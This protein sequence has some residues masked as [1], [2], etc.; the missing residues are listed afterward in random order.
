MDWVDRTIYVKGRGTGDKFWTLLFVIFM[1]A[2]NDSVLLSLHRF[3][4]ELH[5]FSICLE[6]KWI[7][8]KLVESLF[9]V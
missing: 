9:L 5:L 6:T 7:L 2:E 1:A 8:T 4:N 3:E